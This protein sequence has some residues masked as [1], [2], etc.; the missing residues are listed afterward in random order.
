MRQLVHRMHP[1]DL[2]AAAAWLASQ[3][4]PEGAEP[5]TSFEHS[6]SMECG[7]IVQGSHSP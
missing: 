4:V 7:S 3:A 6:P 2:D 1:E 5:E